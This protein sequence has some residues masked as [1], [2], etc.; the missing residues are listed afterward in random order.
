MKIKMKIRYSKS[1]LFV[2]AA[3]LLT[4]LFTIMAT[5]FASDGSYGL[6]VLCLLLGLTVLIAIGFL[7]N[8][9]LTIGKKRLIDIEQ[10][11]ITVLS[12]DDIS[13]IV[14]KFT[15]E[16]ITLYVKTKKQKEHI[17]VWDNIFLGTNVI[18]PSHVR[19]K[20]SNAFVE[21]SIRCLSACPK[22][23]IQNLYTAD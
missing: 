4:G 8:Y 12:Y 21:K 5:A 10:A 23:R 11:G 19:I 1:W 17:T 16:S 14:I 2:V 20:L 15:N 7:F 13:L 22:V 18:L 6:T 9:G 3:A